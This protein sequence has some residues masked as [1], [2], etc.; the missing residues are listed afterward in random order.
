MKRRKIDKKKEITKIRSKKI[1]NST[2]N[3]R[4]KERE[5]D[6]WKEVYSG[7]KLFGKK[8]KNFREKQ[9]IKKQKEEQIKLKE[10]EER[11]LQEQEEQKLQEQ[12][13]RKLQKEQKLKEEEQRRLKAREEQKLEE[14]RIKEEQQEQERQDRIHKEKIRKEQQELER[15]RYI[16]EERVI[17]GDQE[18]LKQLEKV[19]QLRKEEKQVKEERELQ[20]EQKLE[21]KKI[22]EE[23]Q[24]PREERKR[25]NGKVKWFNGAKGYGFIE[26]QDEEKDIF[27]HFSAVKKSGLKYLEKGEQLT[28]EIK[29]SDKGPSAINLQKVTNLQK[30]PVLKL[31]K[32]N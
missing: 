31:V 32:K 22:K 25:L 16:Y 8:Y 10:Q 28:F 6:L 3:K 29:N 24:E 7:L 13:E 19:R 20:K 17:K 9:K 4:I 26:R 14:K 27:V 11:E 30:A 1:K 21:E 2:T 12:E 5:P 18:R 23:Q 15:Q